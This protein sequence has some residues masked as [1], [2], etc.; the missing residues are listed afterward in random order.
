MAK[1]NRGELKSTNDSE[2]PWMAK[3]SESLTRR[4][5]KAIVRVADSDVENKDKSSSGTIANESEPGKV[6]SPFLCVPHGLT[7]FLYIYI[8]ISDYVLSVYGSF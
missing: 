5:E 1:T 6:F 4:D 7:T 8:Y 3:G 2:L